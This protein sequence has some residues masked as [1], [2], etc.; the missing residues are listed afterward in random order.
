LESEQHVKTDD[1]E[2]PPQLKIVVTAKKQK[3]DDGTA[4]GK[5]KDTSAK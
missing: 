4:L 5:A 2:L 1:V 3:M